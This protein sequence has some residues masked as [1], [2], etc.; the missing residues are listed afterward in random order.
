[1]ASAIEARLKREAAVEKASSGR[2]GRAA[3]EA[4]EE[5]GGGVE[6]R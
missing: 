5:K 1:V 3:E 6:M 4:E 2:E